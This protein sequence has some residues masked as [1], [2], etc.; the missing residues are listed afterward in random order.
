MIEVPYTVEDETVAPPAY[1]SEEAAGADMRSNID[2]TIVPGETRM[3]T[4][5]LRM[6]IP[7]YHFGLITSRSGLARKGLVVANAPGVVDSDFRGNMNIL[8]YNRTRSDFQIKKGDRI[9]QLLIVPVEQVTF[10]ATSELNE[11]ERGTKGFGSSGI[12]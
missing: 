6:Q 8:L 10:F 12:N 7:R 2:V 1:M 3:I 11:S 9:A 5:G 4:T